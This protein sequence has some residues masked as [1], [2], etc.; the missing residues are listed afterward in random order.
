MPIQRSKRES[1]PEFPNP[2]LG[3][4]NTTKFLFEDEDE[5]GQK[6]ST[7]STDVKD[8]LH[9]NTTDD[10]FP[11]LVRNNTQPNTVRTILPF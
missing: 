9:M 8:Y 10:N 7:P 4:I 1:V 2:G 5:A 3:H 6:D 11:I